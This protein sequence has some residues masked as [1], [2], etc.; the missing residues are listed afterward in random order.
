MAS[1]LTQEK[2]ME[3]LEWGYEKAVN[4]IPGLDSAKELANDY[5]KQ[6]GTPIEQANSLIRWQNA[7][8]GTSGF[9]TGLGGLITLPIAIPAN[10]ASVLYVQIRMIAAIAHLGGYDISDDRVKTMVFATLTGD[11]AKE[12]L[13]DIG[14]AVG[15]KVA[16]SAINKISGATI[17]KINQAVGFRLLTKFGTTG[18][19]NLGKM[20]PVLGGVVGATFDSVATNIVGNTARN[21]FIGQETP[22]GEATAA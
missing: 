16:L 4:G 11:S 12:V 3:V 8:A 21:I 9:L 17:T 13:K 6:G 20:V 19:I 15:K 2:I 14:I 22:A 1:S 18:I 7:K 10:I 5:A